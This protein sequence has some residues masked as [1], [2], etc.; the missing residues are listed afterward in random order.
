[1]SNNSKYKE[2]GLSSRSVNNRKTVFLLLIIILI[3]GISFYSS[4][5]RESFPEVQIPEI[6]VGTAYPGSSPEFI[7]DKITRPLEKEINTIKDIDEIS[8]TSIHGYSSIRVKFDFKVTPTE[9]LR[10]VKDA[11]DKARGDKDF[12]Q[13][14]PADPNI[15]EM[16]MTDM[17]ILNINLSGDYPVETL[18]DYAE[19]LGDDIEALTEISEVNVRGVQEKQVSVRIRKHDAEAKMVSFGNIE[20]AISQ[21]NF[22]ISGGEIAADGA[23]RSVRVEG[24]FED[25][26]E[27]NDLIVKHEEGNLVYLHEVADVYFT[28]ADI[29]SYAR[30]FDQPVVMLDVKKRSGEN[31]IEAVEKIKV[32]VNEALEKDIPSN[33]SLTLTNDQ[34][35]QIKDQVSNLENS[36]IFGVILVV[37]V[38]LFFLGLRNALF[39]GVAIPLSMFMSFMLLGAAG[40]TLNVM[41]LFSLVLALGMLVDNGIVVVENVYRLMDEEGMNGFEAAKKGVGEVAWPIIA[42]TATTLAAFVPLALWPGMMGEFMQYLPITLMI[43]LGSSLFV[44]LVINPVLTALYMKIQE[45]APN[46]KRLNIIAISM[47]GFGLLMIVVKMNTFGNLLIIFGILAVVNLYFLAPASRKFQSSILPY[48]ETKYRGFLQIA[49][50]RK[51]PI[52]ILIGTFVLLILSLVLTGVFPPK[53]EFFPVNQPNYVNVFIEHPIGTDINTTNETTK[54][55]KSI[56]D[57]TLSKYDDVYSVSRE[58]QEDGSVRTDTNYFVK[59]II[60]QVGE[61]TSDPMQ[62]PSFGTTPHKARIS[63]NFVEFQHRK[64]YKTGVALQEIEA[65]LKNKFNNDIKVVAEKDAA[66]PP[67]GA[68][69][70]IEVSGSENYVELIEK[71]EIIRK[72]LDSKHVEGVKKLALDIELGKPEL[73]LE[74][75]RMRARAY[76][77]STAQ[78]GSQIRTALF[79][80]DVSTYKEGDESYDINLRFDDKYRNNLDALLNQKITFRNNQGKMISIPIRSVVKEPKKTSTYSAVKRIDLENVVTVFSGV[81]EGYNANAVVAEMKEYLEEFKLSSEGQ[82]LIDDGFD[83]KFTGQQEE[84]AKEMAFLS[85][86]LGVAVFLILLIIVTQFNS[87]STPVIILLAVFLSLIGVFLGLLISRQDFIIIMTMIGIISLAGIVVNNAIVLIDYTNLIRTRRRTELGLG[88]NDILPMEEVVKAVIK[89]GQTRLRPV[90]LT[91]ITTVL[92]LIPLA[93]GINI[94][95]FTLFSEFDPQFYIGGDNV[96]FFGPM[97]WTIIYGLTFAT[98]LTLVV[99]PIMYL[100]L[101]KFKL[102]FLR[103]FNMPYRSNI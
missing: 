62:G 15:F 51:N 30:Q 100:L 101:Y 85:T 72:Y 52:K 27:I 102:R 59:S 28:D 37:L 44:A 70:N 71:A 8:S 13:D 50:N 2:F 81:S 54:S 6:Y 74:V 29:T 49:L 19:D 53:V 25:W 96:M 26:K 73:P 5:P 97:S 7:E 64:G 48:L 69:I 68:P 57:S 33:V 67:Q 40:V 82:Q 91:A 78:V 86:A 21:E 87:F 14:L 35:I 10:K 88:E 38:L 43:V 11:V 32:V 31:L 79:G 61:G 3:G 60:E 34:S 9:G 93:V 99:V 80:K 36:I 75:D 92:G 20:Q 23:K 90:L 39:V 46:K 12:P 56:L 17:P 22:T 55:V 24:E 76:G 47:V 103:W 58:K 41:V 89:G 18:K 63:I 94:N 42:S 45:K 84:Q 65:A 1:M 66:G 16:D 98:F 83:Y 77:L 95:F 4:M